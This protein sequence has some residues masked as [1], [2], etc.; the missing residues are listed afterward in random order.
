MA[1]VGAGRTARFSDNSAGRLI[2]MLLPI[3]YRKSP[4]RLPS[5]LMA[6]RYQHTW[7]KDD[8]IA[9]TLD[10]WAAAGWELHTATAVVMG[11]GKYGVSYQCLY[12]RQEA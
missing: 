3:H 8:Q 9:A 6:Y 10:K 2:S 11:M 12:W 7:C 5:G 1:S 4:I